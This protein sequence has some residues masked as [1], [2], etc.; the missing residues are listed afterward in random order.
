MQKH[1]IPLNS[2]VILLISSAKNYY[3]KTPYT[4]K[5]HCDSINMV[6]KFRYQK[7]TIKSLN[8]TVILLI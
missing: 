5:F 6:F 2:T 4:F 3:A 1:L 8:S 7:G